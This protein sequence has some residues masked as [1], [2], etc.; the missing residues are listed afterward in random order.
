MNFK[1]VLVVVHGGG[2][3]V[4]VED[5]MMNHRRLRLKVNGRWLLQGKGKVW[6]WRDMSGGGK[7]QEE[8]F[9]SFC[10]SGDIEERALCVWKLLEQ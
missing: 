2:I 3:A 9:F 1:E 10:E 8:E 5:S 6:K 4:G 7:G